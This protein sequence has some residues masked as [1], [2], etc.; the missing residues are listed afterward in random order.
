MPSSTVISSGPKRPIARLFD[1]GPDVVTPGSKMPVQRLKTVE[2]RDALI[3]FLKRATRPDGDESSRLERQQQR[4][5]RQ[6]SQG[7]TQ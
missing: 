6:Q 3:A 5:E 4:Q 2:D 7:D 1:D